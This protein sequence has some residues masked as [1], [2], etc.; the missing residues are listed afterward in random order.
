LPKGHIKTIGTHPI[1]IRLHPDVDA[2]VALNV[3]AQ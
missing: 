2:A 1:A 3:V